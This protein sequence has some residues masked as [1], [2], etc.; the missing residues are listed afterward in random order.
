[1][2]AINNAR[3]TP[4]GSTELIAWC[5]AKLREHSSYVVEHLGRSARDPRLAPAQTLIEIL[6]DAAG[7]KPGFTARLVAAATGSATSHGELTTRDSR[8]RRTSTDRPRG[9]V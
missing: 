5:E 2:D 7:S 1:M 8:F 6:I 9:F 3:R 4:A